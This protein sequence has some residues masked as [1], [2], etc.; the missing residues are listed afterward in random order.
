M[1]PAVMAQIRFN[2]LSAC[3]TFDPPCFSNSDPFST[4]L[5]STDRS[6]AI[7]PCCSDP[8]T[9][10]GPPIVLTCP[11]SITKNADAGRITTAVQWNPATASGGCGGQINPTCTATNSLGANIEGLIERGG[12]FPASVSEFQCVVTDECGLPTRCDWTVA[13]NPMNTVEAEVQL[14]PTISPALL[15]R[16]VEFEFFANCSSDPVVIQQTFD[17][18]GAF[19]FPGF[20]DS[21]VL[22]VPAGQYLCATARDPLHTLRSAAQPTIVD[23]KYRIRFTHDPL[24]GGN[25]LLG[26]NLNGDHAIDIADFGTL[27][28]Q[29]GAQLQPDTPCGTSAPHADINGD[30]AVDL[31]D[32]SFIDFNL[33]MSDKGV[34]CPGRQGLTSAT[35]LYE[36]SIEQ[37]RR[38]GMENPEQADLNGDGLLNMDDMHLYKAG[39]YPAKSKPKLRLSPG[40]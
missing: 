4:M 40:R 26:G 15:R 33:N 10:N 35:P 34:C 18:G 37:L 29:N 2:S 24:L 19:N 3:T 25:W 21:M 31:L 36:A 39:Q 7:I 16:C 5:D 23:G 6:V 20:S 8:I 12:L 32:F 9:I 17:F 11:S 1:G 27:V 38:M 28:T 30:G 13:V 22:K 14:S